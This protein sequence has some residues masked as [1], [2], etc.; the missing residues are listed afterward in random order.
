MSLICEYAPVVDAERG[1]RITAA[2][3]FSAIQFLTQDVIAL[4][5]RGVTELGK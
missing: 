2:Y 1:E 3:R 4:R 5:I